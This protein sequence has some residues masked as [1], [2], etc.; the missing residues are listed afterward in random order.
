MGVRRA[1]AR[2]FGRA[3]QPFAKFSTYQTP[4]ESWGMTGS[5]CAERL[6]RTACRRRSSSFAIHSIS[7]NQ[8]Y[9]RI[10]AGARAIF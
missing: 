8:P 4:S 3:I 5:V 6:N 9:L 7:V 1:Q 2:L 10:L